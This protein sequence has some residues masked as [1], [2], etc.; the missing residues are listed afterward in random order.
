VAKNQDPVLAALPGPPTTARE[1]TRND[2]L[3]LFTEI[4]E[5]APGAAAH[6]LDITTTMRAEDGRVVLQ[7]REERASTE[8]QG[9]RGGYGYMTRIPLKDYA[10]GLYVIHVEGRSRTSSDE[11]GVGRDV[12]IRIR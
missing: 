11:H 9:G 12:Q 3:A 6:K 8:L 7:N 1:F 10:P 4:Y 5:N 2:E